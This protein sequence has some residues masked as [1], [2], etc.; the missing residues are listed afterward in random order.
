[1]VKNTPQV[2]R[3]T[4]DIFGA[5]AEAF[6]FVFETLRRYADADLLTLVNPSQQGPWQ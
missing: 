4:Q 3:G 6:A 1:M 2:I 5:D